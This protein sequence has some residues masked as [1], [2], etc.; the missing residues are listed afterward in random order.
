MT[1]TPTLQR[2]LIVYDRYIWRQGDQFP[3]A[4]SD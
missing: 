1:Q 3:E 2:L 4:E